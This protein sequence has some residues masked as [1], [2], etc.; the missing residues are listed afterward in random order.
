MLWSKGEDGELGLG[1]RA[2]GGVAPVNN[3][4]RD[5]EPLRRATFRGVDDSLP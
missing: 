1:L 4:P 5:D 2:D 3:R